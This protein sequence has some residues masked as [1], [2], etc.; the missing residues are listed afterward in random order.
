VGCSDFPCNQEAR[1][2]S[3]GKANAKLGVEVDLVSREGS[4]KGRLKGGFDGAR[5]HGDTVQASD[6][7]GR[8]EVQ[9]SL[10]FGVMEKLVS[11]K[12]MKDSVMAGHANVSARYVGCFWE[13]EHLHSAHPLN[14]SPHGFQMAGVGHSGFKSSL[15]FA[16]GLR[17]L[18]CRVIHKSSCSPMNGRA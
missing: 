10:M 6:A 12:L 9:K 2:V 15:I 18:A 11:A 4:S 1:N 16:C 14:L 17:K 5:P 8:R 13:I 7:I 3:V